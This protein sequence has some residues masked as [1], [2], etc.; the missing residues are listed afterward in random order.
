MLQNFHDIG[1]FLAHDTADTHVNRLLIL[2]NDEN[3]RQ[4]IDFVVG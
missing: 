1:Q 4:R 2:L 3:V